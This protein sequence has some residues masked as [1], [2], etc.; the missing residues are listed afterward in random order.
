MESLYRISVTCFTASYLVVFLIELARLYTDAEWVSG[1]ILR[2]FQLLMVSAGLFAHTIFLAIYGGWDQAGAKPWLTNWFGWCLSASWLLIL[3]YVWVSVRQPRS[4]IG[5]FLLPM[6][7]GMIWFA[8]LFGASASFTAAYTRSSW[9]FIHGASLLLGTS[10]VTLGFIFGIAYLINSYRL[11]SKS[12][13]LI[14]IRFPSLEWLQHSAERCLLISAA[15]LGVGLASG[16]AI[17]LIPNPESVGSGDRSSIWSDPVVWTSGILFLW[18]VVAVI[19]SLI[20]QPARQGRKV[21]YLIVASFFFLVLELIIVWW[22]GHATEPKSS[23]ERGFNS[24]VLAR[25]GS[26]GNGGGG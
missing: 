21:A 12:E 25:S 1:K 19:F 26:D 13:W 6:A 20:Y 10:L 9:N 14:R 17:S 18:L 11:K 3:S 8:H 7:L 23:L 2:V 22:V 4:G 5:I 24:H 16:I 15:L